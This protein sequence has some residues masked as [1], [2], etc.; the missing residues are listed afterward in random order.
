M[1]EAATDHPD[2][3]PTDPEQTYI[4]CGQTVTYDTTPG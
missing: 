4:H 1:F 2:L 3:E